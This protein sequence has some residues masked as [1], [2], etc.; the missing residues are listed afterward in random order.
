MLK[1][2]TVC[3]FRVWTFLVGTL[4]QDPF[5]ELTFAHIF[6]ILGSPVLS[7]GRPGTPQHEAKIEKEHQKSRR[8]TFSLLWDPLGAQRGTRIRFLVDLGAAGEPRAHFVVDLGW[9]LDGFG[10]D[11]QRVCA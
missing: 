6:L 3:T 7:R 9:M 4:S 2:V 10:M 11:F 5:S 1:C 8:N